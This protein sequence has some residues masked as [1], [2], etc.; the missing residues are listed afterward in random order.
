M[1]GFYSVF[2]LTMIPWTIRYYH[3]LPAEYIQIHWR[4]MWIVFDS[5]LFVLGAL[6]SYLLIKK[7]AWAALLLTALATLFVTDMWFDF[8]M[9]VTAIERH[10]VLKITIAAEIPLTILSVGCAIYI[11]H[12]ALS[13]R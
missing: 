2:A 12:Q 7:S 1:S 6:T 11:L 13:R 5:S 8:M 3:T 4:I 9:A 10:A